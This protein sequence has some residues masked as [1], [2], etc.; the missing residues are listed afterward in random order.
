MECP[1]C[2]GSIRI[3]RVPYR[4]KNQVLLGEFE[5]E[6][7]NNCGAKY[8]DESTFIEILKRAKILGIWGQQIIPIEI[9]TVATE[10]NLPIMSM[11][12]LFEPPSIGI[13][14]IVTAEGV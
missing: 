11:S 2:G 1:E 10:S 7:C 4:Y 8:F 13:R 9:S 5:A 6:I 12:E 14:R 3:E